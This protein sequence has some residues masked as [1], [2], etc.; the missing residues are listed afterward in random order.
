MKVDPKFARDIIKL[1]GK[2]LRKCM[3]CANCSVVC[4]LSPEDDP[5][6]RKEMIWAGW[7]LKE[8]VLRDPNVW[9]CYNCG[10]CSSYCPRDAKPGQVMNAI[11]A[12]V[13][14]EFTWPK[15]VGRILNKP[16]GFPIFVIIIPAIIL[17]ALIAWANPGIFAGQ[18]PSGVV[19]TSK[20]IDPYHIEV[21]AFIMGGYVI[22]I[23]LISLWRY[24]LAITDGGGMEYTV[25]PLE[26][27]EVEVKGKSGFMGMYFLEA[28]FFVLRDILYHNWFKMCEANKPRF[29]A[30]LLIFYGFIA[31]F[32]SAL[33]DVIGIGEVLGIKLPVKLV[34]PPPWPWELFYT[35]DTAYIIMGLVKLLAMLGGLAIM[36]GSAVAI[37]N[38]IFNKRSKEFG[39]YYDW[40]FLLIV[41]LVGITGYGVVVARLLESTSAYWIYLIHL[42]FV[43]MLLVYAPYS[44]FAHLLYRTVAMIYAWTRD[45][46]P[47]APKYF[48]ERFWSSI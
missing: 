20:L 19:E 8:K 44:K 11:R 29:P 5:F 43:F 27:A 33:G 1:G 2:D 15:F 34:Y 7:G 22:I 4:P 3:Q 26:N 12:R 9:L 24:W 46:Y 13:I 30:H 28:F 16:W 18:L 37:W 35:G 41:F 10:D 40:F 23:A 14:S 38:W 47:E 45:K 32:I 42:Y 48:W 31:L 39:S 21:P 36:V 6:P 25:K 17:S